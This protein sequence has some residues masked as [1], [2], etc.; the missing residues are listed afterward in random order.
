MHS[1][2]C[3]SAVCNIS[4]VLHRHGRDSD[5]SAPRLARQGV[6]GRK[7]K[8]SSCERDAWV[9]DCRL[10][11]AFLPVHVTQHSVGSRQAFDSLAGGL[12]GRS[13]LVSVD[14]KSA[15]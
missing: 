12:L 6:L 11:V 9:A 14:E 3:V 13:E 15:S 10:C 7:W 2:V 1:L 4:V 8:R 5:L